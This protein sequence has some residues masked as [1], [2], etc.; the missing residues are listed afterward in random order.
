M[1]VLK[2]ALGLM[3]AGLLTVG[4]AMA[5]PASQ[6]FACTYYD[7]NHEVQYSSKVFA[8]AGGNSDPNAYLGDF[9][10]AIHAQFHIP[11]EAKHVECHTV[12][13]WRVDAERDRLA[14]LAGA[15]AGND[16]VVAWPRSAS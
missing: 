7:F 4:P 14:Q 10:A 12:G 8:S 5:Q 6:H 3:A 15:H 2:S 13:E 9:S 1:I 16:R 11:V